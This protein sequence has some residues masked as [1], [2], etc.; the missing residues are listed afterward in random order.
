MS[1]I[2]EPVET[3]EIAVV[4]H[5]FRQAYLYAL[6]TQAEV[7]N[8]VRTQ[9]LPEER[10]QAPGI[11]ESWRALQPQVQHLQTAEVGLAETISLVALP[12]EADELVKGFA[13][14]P[15]FQ[16]TFATLPSQFSMVEVDKLVAAQR[17]VNLDYVERL[18]ASYPTSPTLEDLLNI[19]VSPKRTMEPI[20]HL[21][22]APNTHVFSSPNSDIRFIGAFLKQNLT[23]EDLAYAEQGG[24]PAAAIIAFVGYGAAPINVLMA[25]QRVVLNNGFH[26]VYALRQLGVMHIP[27]VV[28]QIR[29]PQLEFPPAIAGLPS[30]YLLGAARPV[31]IKDF[32]EPG[33]TITLK[34]RDRVKMVTVGIARNEHEVPS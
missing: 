22:V 26:R 8:H 25:G 13:A 23:P 27:V 10:D 5:Y 19:C 7:L 24:I 15:A 6:A 12:S 2:F 4:T 9:A 34:V 21:E 16:K 28:Q 1:S 17:T 33:F 3:P 29:N 11:L 31:L 30:E 20:Q 14:D 18:V 32:F